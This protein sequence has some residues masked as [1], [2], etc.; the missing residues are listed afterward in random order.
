MPDLLRG[1]FSREQIKGNHSVRTS[2]ILW[3]TAV[4]VVVEDLTRERTAVCSSLCM[5]LV[6]FPDCTCRVF[7]N[8]SIVHMFI[9]NAFVG[10]EFSSY[11]FVRDEFIRNAP[12][13]LS[14]SRHKIFHTVISE[15]LRG[16][17]TRSYSGISI[18]RISRSSGVDN[19]PIQ[20]QQ[21]QRTMG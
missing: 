11:A 14:T 3:Y 7:V 16:G 15:S 2:L 18:A 9:S 20:E 4:V 10:D 21:R 12:R 6:F 19:S 13:V 8:R 5:K 1:L 17:S